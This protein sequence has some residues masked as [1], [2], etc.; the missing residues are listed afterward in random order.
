MQKIIYYWKEKNTESAQLWKKG[1]ERSDPEWP[2]GAQQT[3]F[4]EALKIVKKLTHY[5]AEEGA[6]I[7][8]RQFN[9]ELIFNG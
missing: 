7:I 5:S 3:L 9:F 1:Q 2:S 6:K 4:I 8:I